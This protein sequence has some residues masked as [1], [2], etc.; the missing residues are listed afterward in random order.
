[1]VRTLDAHGA[2]VVVVKHQSFVRMFVLDG[3]HT[4]EQ[5]ETASQ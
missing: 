4:Y 3:V 1:M 2:L 5:S